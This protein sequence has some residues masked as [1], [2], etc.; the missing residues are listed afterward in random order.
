MDTKRENAN[1]FSN[2]KKVKRSLHL[3]VIL[4]YI[5]VA[6]CTQQFHQLGEAKVQFDFKLKEYITLRISLILLA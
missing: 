3:R 2:I 5:F 4:V 6:G 1:S